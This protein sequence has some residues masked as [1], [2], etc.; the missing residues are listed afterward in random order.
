M[1]KSAKK[2]KSTAGAKPADLS[3]FIKSMSSSMIDIDA[4]TDIQRKNMEAVLEANRKAAEG[5]QSVFQRQ[6][7]ILQQAIEDST[8]ALKEQI[9]SAQTN[10]SPEKHVA[11]ARSNVEAAIDNMR[12]LMDMAQKT[13][14]RSL[15]IV[16]DRITKSIEELRAATDR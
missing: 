8:G 14:A 10:P 12:E 15:K 11:Q 16:Q 3:A 13:N 4:V 9:K 1:T 6:V 2:A 5:Y 7:E